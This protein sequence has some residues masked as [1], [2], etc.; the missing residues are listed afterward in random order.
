[1]QNLV[2]NQEDF[3]KK[4]RLYCRSGFYE[5]MITLKVEHMKRYLRKLFKLHLFVGRSSVGEMILNL[6]LSDA[7]E[8]YDSGTFRIT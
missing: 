8:W 4:F 6:E 1:M 3:K 7:K 5:L 2:F